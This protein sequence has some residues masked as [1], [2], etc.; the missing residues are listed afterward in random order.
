MIESRS[1]LPLARRSFVSRL[2]AGVAAFGATL[3]AGAPR[4]QAQSTSDA[5]WQ[6]ARHAQDDWFDQI[7]GK[8][9][10][11]FDTTTP[12]SLADAIQFVG[13]YFS[14]NKSGY[15][16]ENT[17]LAVVVCLRHRSAPFGLNDAMWAK[18]GVTLATRA[19][20]TDPKTK[21]APTT[22]LFA[23]APASATAPPAVSLV[24]AG[25]VKNRPVR[26]LDARH[27]GVDCAGHRRK[28]R[29]D[30]QGNHRQPDR[31]RAARAGGHRRG[32]PRAGARLLDHVSGP[33]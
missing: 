14:A 18:Y 3:V 21:E 19:Q 28:G 25:A 26:L 20:F 2:G 23:P 32:Q 8:H 33:E 17:E 12:D 6:P 30:L 11:F 5:R 7:P 10:L 16:L 13:N 29:R 4:L 1:R 22:N 27:R 31:Q 9:R 15:G 24:W